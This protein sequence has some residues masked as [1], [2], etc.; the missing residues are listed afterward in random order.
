MESHIAYLLG[1]KSMSEIQTKVKW[2]FLED[3][4]V[5]PES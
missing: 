1:S 5:S 4:M 2:I 3:L